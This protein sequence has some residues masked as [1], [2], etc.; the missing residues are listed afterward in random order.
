MLVKIIQQLKFV[1]TSCE[2]QNKNQMTS[3]K[4]N[5]KCKRQRQKHI[6]VFRLTINKLVWMELLCKGD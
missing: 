2:K 5:G 3:G 6:S 1:L 4:P